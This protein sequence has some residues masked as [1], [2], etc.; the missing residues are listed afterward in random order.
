MHSKLTSNKLINSHKCYLYSAVLS[1]I[2]VF[3]GSRGYMRSKVASNLKLNEMEMFC[4]WPLLQKFPKSKPKRQQ[5]QQTVFLTS[6]FSEVSF[7][8][9]RIWTSVFKWL[10]LKQ[11]KTV[12][13]P[14]KL[15]IAVL[16]LCQQFVD[17]IGKI[18]ILFV[19]FE[20]NFN[21]NF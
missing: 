14:W 1:W 7:G 19:S 5:K 4:I 3:V 20:C 16:H 10:S 2:L 8:T 11:W 15:L 13:K 18:C 21:S 9:E 17:K 6:L 12:S